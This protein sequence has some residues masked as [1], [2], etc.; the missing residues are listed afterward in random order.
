[1]RGLLL[2]GAPPGLD[3]GAGAAQGRSSVAVTVRYQD[4]PQAQGLV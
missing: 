2:S 1:M 3:A 4:A